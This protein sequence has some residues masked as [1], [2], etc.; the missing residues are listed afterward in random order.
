VKPI[1]WLICF[2][3]WS[4]TALCL[5]IGVGNSF[6][7]GILFSLRPIEYVGGFYLG[8]LFASYGFSFYKY[9][10]VYVI[11]AFALSTVMYFSG[12]GGVSDFSPDRFYA[13]T[14]GPYEL[15][16]VMAF[17]VFYF[18]NENKKYSH[19]MALLSFV[20]L[21]CTLSRVTIFAT[22]IVALISRYKSF[23]K[24]ENFF[25]ILIAL[26]VFTTLVALFPGPLTAFQ[27]RISLAF[28]A[29]TITGVTELWENADAV[30]THQDYISSVYNEESDNE[31]FRMR[32][33][34]STLI[35]LKRWFTILK[36]IPESN[37]HVFAG[38]GP[39]FASVAVDG[40]FVRVLVE[41]GA[42]G[43]LIFSGFFISI[44][45]YGFFKKD[46]TLCQFAMVLL[47][48]SCFIDI[49][50]ASKVMFLFWF[51]MGVRYFSLLPQLLTSLRLA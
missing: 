44:L 30:S 8:Y 36:S 24:R 25:F 12:Y 1:A 28:S 3:I 2:T 34:H 7:Q 15:A 50:V 29:D 26:I 49:F 22:I 13:N 19:I 42:I 37:V 31:V 35:R 16:P 9:V 40:Y 41:T 33:D 39:S 48:T 17:S 23:L 6:F 45:R 20:V 11:Y 32:G 18:I 5:N 27:K 47:F 14:N 38:F 4:F 51:Y 43:L 21:I 10:L 46:Y